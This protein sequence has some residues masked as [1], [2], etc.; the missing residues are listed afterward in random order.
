MLK[1]KRPQYYTGPIAIVCWNVLA[2]GEFEDPLL[3]IK[4]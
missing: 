3:E 4:L 2:L 1:F